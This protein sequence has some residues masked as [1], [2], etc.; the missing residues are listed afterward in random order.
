MRLKDIYFLQNECSSYRTI[1]DPTRNISRE[2]YSCQGDD[3][4]LT[5]GWYQFTG[6]AGDMM[7]NY[8]P[9]NVGYKYHC[10]SQYKGWM[11][12]SLPE[13]SD[14]IVTRYVKDIFKFNET[15]SVFKSNRASKQM[16][17]YQSHIML[18]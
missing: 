9:T 15:L 17:T 1:S 5:S 14:G 3:Y 2:G 11:N 6:A 8:C 7:L 13:Q 4:Y 18:E 10:G 12:G 16:I